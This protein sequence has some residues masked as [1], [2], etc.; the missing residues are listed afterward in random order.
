MILTDTPQKEIF[1]SY[2]NTRK[3]NEPLPKQVKNVRR[4]LYSNKNSDH[5]KMPQLSYHSSEYLSDSRKTSETANF[6]ELNKPPEINN[7][8]LIDFNTLPKN[9]YVEKIT[10]PVASPRREPCS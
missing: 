4:H 10:K 6:Q 2:Q 9:C 1:N 8:V 3:V 5:D 7:F